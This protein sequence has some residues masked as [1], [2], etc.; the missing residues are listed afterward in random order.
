MR[1]GKPNE[2]LKMVAEAVGQGI[3]ERD[4]GDKIGVSYLDPAA[5]AQD[6]GPSIAER[7]NKNLN[8]GMFIRA[9]NKRVGAKGAMGGWDQLRA[10]IVGE[11]FGDPWGERPMIYTFSSCV[12]SIR[13]IPVLQHDD[14]RPEDLDTKAEDHAADEWRYGVMSRPYS[15]RPPQEKEAMRG[16]NQMTLNELWKHNKPKKQRI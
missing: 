3:N 13:T 11:D 9:D 4:G 7:I 6:G 5:F 12:D 14:T 16:A 15:P 1:K 10:R 8:T 2:G